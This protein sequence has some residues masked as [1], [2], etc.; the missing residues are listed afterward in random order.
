MQEEHQKNFEMVLSD[1][2]CDDFCTEEIVKKFI[3]HKDNKFCF[4]IVF[5]LCIRGCTVYAKYHR[6]G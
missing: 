6:S 3:C 4:S 2:D 5:P 1:D